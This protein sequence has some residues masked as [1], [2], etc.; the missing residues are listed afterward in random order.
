MLYFRNNS[1]Y[2]VNMEST[3]SGRQKK[4]ESEDEMKTD[5]LEKIAEIIGGKVWMNTPYIRIYMNYRKDVKAFFNFTNPNDLT[6]F[7]FKIQINECGQ[8]KN[9][10]S[11]QKQQ[12]LETYLQHGLAVLFLTYSDKTDVAELIMEADY[13]LIKEL[14]DELSHQIINGE[15]TEVED[16]LNNIQ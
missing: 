9:W 7:E 14:I 6:E 4:E 2:N 10:Y 8:H 16:T 3:W 13:D 11:S 5:K 15:L 1:K 12:I